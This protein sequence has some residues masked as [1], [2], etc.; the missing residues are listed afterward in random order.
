MKLSVYMKSKILVWLSAAALLTGGYVMM[1][2]VGLAGEEDVWSETEY[3]APELTVEFGDYYVDWTQGIQYDKDKYVLDIVDSDEASAHLFGSAGSHKIEYRLR[4][5]AVDDELVV[6]AH[7]ETYNEM[8]D[9]I[10]SIADILLE[11]E[12]DPTVLTNYQQETELLSSEQSGCDDATCTDTA[13]DESVAVEDTCVDGETCSDDDCQSGEN[14]VI[15]GVEECD[16]NEQCTDPVACAIESGMLDG[17]SEDDLVEIGG[18]TIELKYLEDY[19]IIYNM[20][21]D[22][23]REEFGEKVTEGIYFFRDIIIQAPCEYQDITFMQN[24]EYN[25][26]QDI[27][28]NQD[29]YSIKVLNED[30]FDITSVYTHVMEYEL[31]RNQDGIT[32]K[33]DRTVYLSEEIDPFKPSTYATTMSNYT[34]STPG[35]Y[36]HTVS[37]TNTSQFISVTAR[38]ATLHL[39]G[40]GTLG[41]IICSTNVYV[42]TIWMETGSTVNFTSTTGAAITGGGT[43][44]TQIFILGNGRLN[45]TGAAGGDAGAPVDNPFGTHGTGSTCIVSSYTG[46]FSGGTGGTGAYPG[47]TAVKSLSIYSNNNNIYIYGGSTGS[48]GYGGAG[49]HSSGIISTT[50]VKAGAGGGGAGYFALAVG[51][52]AGS[53]SS[54]GSTGS[55]GAGSLG[56]GGGSTPSTSMNAYVDG[57]GVIPSIGSC[58]K[59]DRS[60]YLNK[61]RGAYTSTSAVYAACNGYNSSGEK[62]SGGGTSNGVA[63]SS[64]GTV[65]SPTFLHYNGATYSNAKGYTGGLE[66]KTNL[67]STIGAGQDFYGFSG[68]ASSITAAP[69]RVIDVVSGSVGTAP[70]VSYTPAPPIDLQ[71]NYGDGNLSTSMVGWSDPDKS[72]RN[73][74]YTIPDGYE[75]VGYTVTSYN[76]SF[77]LQRTINYDVSEVS[78]YDVNGNKTGECMMPAADAQASRVYWGVAVII[79][80]GNGSTLTSPATITTFDTSPLVSVVKPDGSGGSFTCLSTALA[81]IQFD[82]LVGTEE[83]PAEYRIIYLANYSHN[84][85]I[86]ALKNDDSSALIN[87]S[88]DNVHLI[89]ESNYLAATSTAHTQ[90]YKLTATTFSLPKNVENVSVT[91]RDF[92][93]SATTVVTYGCDFTI[94]S[95]SAT[96]TN[97]RSVLATEIGTIE[98]TLGKTIDIQGVPNITNMYLDNNEFAPYLIFG[99]NIDPEDEENG[100][101]GVYSTTNITGAYLLELR[102][103]AKLTVATNLV[104]GYD[105]ENTGDDSIDSS[106]KLGQL[107]LNGDSYLVVRGNSTTNAISDL[108]TRGSRPILEF[109]STFDNSSEDVDSIV[110]PLRIYGEGIIDEDGIEISIQNSYTENDYWIGRDVIQF[111]DDSKI[112][113]NDYY[114]NRFDFAIDTNTHSI[115]IAGYP[116]FRVQVTFPNKVSMDFQTYRDAVDYIHKMYTGT[117]AGTYTISLIDDYDY[118]GV[119][120]DG[121]ESYDNKALRSLYV[122]SGNF[123][124][125]SELRDDGSGDSEDSEDGEVSEDRYTFIAGENNQGYNNIFCLPE[126]TAQTTVKTLFCD[127]DLGFIENVYVG[128]VELELYGTFYSDNPLTFYGSY[129]FDEE[130][131]SSKSVLSIIASNIIGLDKEGDI[132]GIGIVGLGK[133]NSY[134]SSTVYVNEVK[135]AANYATEFQRY[136]SSKIHYQK[137]GI[138]EW[139]SIT[140]NSTL[141]ESHFNHPEAIIYVYGSGFTH[142]TTNR[143]D[144]LYF[145]DPLEAINRDLYVFFTAQGEENASLAITTKF[146]LSADVGTMVAIEAR[147]NVISTNTYV[148]TIAPDV[149][150]DTDGDAEEEEIVYG[151]KLNF[152][153]SLSNAIKGVTSDNRTGEYEVIFIADYNLVAADNTE[154]MN[155][156]RADVGFNFSSKQ[157]S[158]LTIEGNRYVSISKE[159]E[160]S[161]LA[162]MWS[163]MITLITSDEDDTTDSDPYEGYNLLTLVTE[164]T[165]GYETIILPSTYATPCYFNDIVFNLTTS[166][167]TALIRGGGGGVTVDSN[168]RATNVKE[169]YPNGVIDVSGYSHTSV[170][171]FNK[172]YQNPYVRV[173]GGQYRNIYGVREYAASYTSTLTTAG[174]T[175]K[176]YL[177]GG[178]VANLYGGSYAN[179]FRRTTEIH[180]S[181]GVVTDMLYVSNVGTGMGSLYLYGDHVLPYTKDYD[182]IYIEEDATIVMNGLLTRNLNSSGAPYGEIHFGANS[183]LQL[184]EVPEGS[185]TTVVNTAGQL[186]T[187]GT[188]ASLVMP[189]MGNGIEPLRIDLATRPTT[190]TNGLLTVVPAEGF[191]YKS[192]TYVQNDEGIWEEE[193][194]EEGGKNRFTAGDYVLR[195]SATTAYGADIT[196]YNNGFFPLGLLGASPSA[197]YISLGSMPITMAK[198]DGEQ[199]YYTSISAAC[200]EI[201]RDGADANDIDYTIIIRQEGYTISTADTTGLSSYGKNANSITFTSAYRLTESDTLLAGESVGDSVK[202]LLYISGNMTCYTDMYF[203]NILVEITSANP[204]IYAMGFDLY[205]G[206]NKAPYLPSDVNPGMVNIESN[207]PNVYGGTSSNGAVVDETHVELG[208]GRY[209]NIYGG[210]YNGRVTEDT[211]VQLGNV[212]DTSGT[213]DNGLTIEGDVYGAGYAYTNTAN[214]G[215]VGGDTNILIYNATFT[216]SNLVIVGGGAYRYR[217]I[218]T[219]AANIIIHKAYAPESDVSIIGTDTA[220]IGSVYIEVVEGGTL[221][222]NSAA[223]Y[224]VRG[225]NSVSNTATGTIEEDFEVRV[226]GGNGLTSIGGWQYSRNFLTSTSDTRRI[227]GEINIYMGAGGSGGGV[228]GLDAL[229]A[230]ID[231]IDQFDNLYIGYNLEGSSEEETTVATGNSRGA[232]HVTITSWLCG[233]PVSTREVNYRYGTI[234]LMEGSSLTLPT[235]GTVAAYDLIVDE[236]LP[237]LYIGKENVDSATNPLVLNGNN[238]SGNVLSDDDDDETT[239]LLNRL[240]LGLQSH[241][242]NSLEEGELAEVGD[243]LIRYAVTP[244]NA[245]EYDYV[246]GVDKFDII[247]SPTES[248][249]IEYGAS[250]LP[251]ITQTLVEHKDAE[252]NV[253]VPATGMSSATNSNVSGSLNTVMKTL[254]FNFLNN[255]EDGEYSGFEIEQGYI[256]NTGVKNTAW[257]EGGDLPTGVTEIEITKIDGTDMWSGKVSLDIESYGISQKAYYAHVRDER[258]SVKVIC[259]DVHSPVYTQDPVVEQINGGDYNITLTMT[260]PTYQEAMGSDGEVHPYNAAGI[261]QGAWTIGTSEGCPGQDEILENRT[262]TMSENVKDVIDIH[263]LSTQF[264]GTAVISKE[265]LENIED[266][267][268]TVIYIYLKDNL[269]NTRQVA[270]PM[271]EFC[272]DVTIPTR[273]AMIAIADTANALVAP[274]CFVVNNGNNKVKAEVIGA[275]IDADNDIEFVTTSELLGKNKMWLVITSDYRPYDY[276]L[277]YG[278]ISI[279][280]LPVTTV[281]IGNMSPATE[282]ENAA[283]F[284]FAALY[285]ENTLETTGDWSLFNMRYRFTVLAD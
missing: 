127:F 140:N 278:Y 225:A 206:T 38:N 138:Y 151:S 85:A 211:Y 216:K 133:V 32:Y 266:M 109:T 200:A 28:Y 77:T 238:L 82:S 89:F 276:M 105:L 175:P 259:L 30:D 43:S 176:V 57:M 91:F 149:I 34:I 15:V 264:T 29:E 50:W 111:T 26:L 262:M 125:S 143:Y 33:F 247:V 53:G 220:N 116:H 145:S 81:Y 240:I 95:C 75:I 256:T 243:N 61:S 153:G 171:N 147:D 146:T 108:V 62:T 196:P 63:S 42:L 172:L 229:V 122:A 241:E 126:N 284:T 132:Q 44:R 72:G 120:G 160:T 168:I 203:D 265:E 5:K 2:Q 90:R 110:A 68:N 96:I 104:L 236:S 13:C 280:H 222:A 154:L 156:Y 158:E 118:L 9:F 124:F 22:E 65:A 239:Q 233:I 130:Y 178:T 17:F 12:A 54:G 52:Q 162:N 277:E 174:V 48:A 234:H 232:A 260:D 40:S 117:A 71:V 135:K 58:H 224:G 60:Y 74:G 41:G 141:I 136:A 253:T 275:D 270:I 69:T 219:G 23:L 185:A 179:A 70:G 173:L 115:E 164:N 76:S 169:D 24:G 210:S 198:N 157:R 191:E 97:L 170:A 221:L 14:A 195:F 113:L 199:E 194:E 31:T 144:Y 84:V 79:S 129:D 213:I 94:E 87:F 4:D 279:E 223:V 139:G 45:V 67:R 183:Q 37:G 217:A 237:H 103:N 212:K 267:D 18:R 252:G 269:G 35:T 46:S 80:N 119:G 246:S 8:Q 159:D 201:N 16:K 49:Y 188:G 150:D 235:T 83:E 1:E 98:N 47:V 88:K 3:M 107:T 93:M 137:A 218:V 254:H 282:G 193:E 281:H 250:S 7:L 273:V 231:Y 27:E 257:G 208:S 209:N 205:M 163:Y 192:P 56:G 128:N 166:T 21:I 78:L 167:N 189:K 244:A 152:Y 274:K 186:I 197:G 36:T 6:Q 114:S 165:Y 64:F 177:E 202:R 102:E 134:A 51:S 123:Q 181:G 39:S 248:G 155:F 182:Y 255:D 190:V 100:T 272:I 55:G 258:G 92:Y 187:E 228:G 268:N 11:I 226:H 73:T 214:Y 20:K 227:S 101:G 283:Y 121:I 59:T 261:Y 245:R 99:N 142:T 66:G 242:H 106:E 19:N 204:N 184:Y 263:S 249:V 148:A 112:N 25:L 207:F 271:S 251:V 161:L 86:S 180:I 230:E 215:S 285:E 10:E 131:D